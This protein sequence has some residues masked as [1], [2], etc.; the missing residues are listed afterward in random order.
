MGKPSQETWQ[1]G[2]GPSSGLWLSC[3]IFPAA[4]GEMLSGGRLGL[5]QMPK[6]GRRWRARAEEKRWG[7]LGSRDLSHCGVYLHASSPLPLG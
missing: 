7:A 1:V 6:G 4:P 5:D 2:V 3:L